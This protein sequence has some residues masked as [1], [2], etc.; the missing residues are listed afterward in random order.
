MV[1]SYLPPENSSALIQYNKYF[2][3]RFLRT[4]ILSLACAVGHTEC[5]EDVTSIFLSWINDENDVRPHP[6]IRT[7]VYYYGK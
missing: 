2:L 1:F 6:D 4:T 3:Y 5:L 7:L